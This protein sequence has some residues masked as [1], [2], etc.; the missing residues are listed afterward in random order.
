MEA[1]G[2]YH[3]SLAYEL[4]KME[5]RVSLANPHR[6]REF[7]RGMGILTKNDRVDA[8]MLACYGALK[9]PEAWLPPPEEVRYLSALLCRRDAL[10]ADSAREKNRLEK[11]LRHRSVVRNDLNS[12]PAKN[13]ISA[14]RRLW[15]CVGSGKYPVSLAYRM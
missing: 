9:A 5:A 4:H 12:R 6:T 14:G 1:T 2:V 15:L 13:G 8:Y 7:A 10:V 3:E 11:Y